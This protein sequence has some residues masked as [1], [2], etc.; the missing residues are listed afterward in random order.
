MSFDNG[1][2]WQSLRLNL[3]VTPVHDIAVTDNDVIIATHGR[4]F[5]VLDDVA[6]LRQLTPQVAQEAVHLFTP[7]DARPLGE[8]RRQHRL[9]PGERGGEGDASTC[10]TRRGSWSA[11]FTGTAE[12]AAKKDQAEAQPAPDEEGFRRVEP[13]VAV[14]AGMNRFVWD[15]RYPGPV[16]IPKMILWAAGTRGPKAVPGSYQVRL[17][18]ASAGGPRA[19]RRSSQTAPFA[20][21]KHPLLTLGDRRRLPGA[22]R[23]GHAGA[24]PGERGRRGGHPDPLAQGPGE[25]PGGRP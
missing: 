2:D 25:E 12:A 14:K 18:V 16:E 5:Y 9:L 22:V 20:I 3:P 1:A 11:A 19:P 4:S 21:R 10:S 23:P 15:M 17:T 7:Q 8:P 24:G 6:V 13:K